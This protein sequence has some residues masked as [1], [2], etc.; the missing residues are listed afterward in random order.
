MV[1]FDKA[2]RWWK[3]AQP[4][5]ARFGLVAGTRVAN[6]IA[7]ADYRL[8][9]GTEVKVFVP[10]WQAPLVIRAGTSDADVIRQ[11]V[12]QRELEIKFDEAPR[13]IVDAGANI[14]VSVRVFAAMW[15]QADILAI[16]LDA[17]NADLLRRNSAP[18]KRVVTRHGGLW[19]RKGWVSVQNP[20][21]DKW[22][23]AAI[24]QL[25]PDATAVPSF[26]VED[27]LNEAAWD[28]VDLLKM[29]IEGGEIEV[30]G[31][32][33]RWIHRCRRIVVELH[34]RYVPGCREAMERALNPA[35][36]HLSK[37]REYVV[38]ERRKW[39]HSGMK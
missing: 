1:A 38:A 14:G 33:D 15:P 35:D 27:L 23:F 9:P 2:I 3:F 24:E 8:V 16:E 34:D 31:T 18:Y 12:V 6:A 30:F 7:N 4:Y 28:T 29:D 36:W 13:R 26:T 21:A 17:G 11:V 5:R 22:S 32:A 19:G 37:H 25:V 39:P 20:A 10:E